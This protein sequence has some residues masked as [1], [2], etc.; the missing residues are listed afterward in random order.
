MKLDGVL[1]AIDGQMKMIESMA[2]KLEMVGSLNVSDIDNLNSQSDL[3]E[4]QQ[5]EVSPGANS[6]QA[7]EFGNLPNT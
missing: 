1:K 3:V 5:Q 6:Q 7:E 2:K 4:E